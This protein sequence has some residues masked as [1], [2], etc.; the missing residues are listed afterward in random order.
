M[1]RLRDIL[2]TIL[3]IVLSLSLAATPICGVPAPAFGTI[4]FADRA[5]VGTAAASIGTTILNG[6]SL[7]T[8][9]L[10][11]LQVRAGAA[12]LLLS[13]SSRVTWSAEAEAPAATLTAG[14]AT[15]STADSKAFAL[16]MATAVIRPKGDEPTVGSVTF[17]NP[18]E[19]TVQ[20]SRGV[21]VLAVDDDTLEIS[22]GTAYHVILDPDPS[23]AA[24]AAKDPTNAWGSNQKPKKSG[25]NRF[26]FF[27]IF[28]GAAVAALLARH[29]A[30]ES[31]DR[32]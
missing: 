9:E 7:H 27:W 8:E 12:R 19:L 11:S 13:A 18:K 6:D 23:M 30:V 5:H 32:P 29:F 3:S 28:G 2:G 25:K 24:A 4:L 31:P 22:G 16:R 21:L 26:I 1:A 20:C 10:G 15:F 17:L 14:T